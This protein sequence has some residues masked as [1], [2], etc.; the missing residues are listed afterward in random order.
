MSQT[1]MMPKCSILMVFIVVFM[2][3]PAWFQLPQFSFLSTMIRECT[4]DLGSWKVIKVCDKYLTSSSSCL[5]SNLWATLFHVF[6]LYFF[7]L[8][9]FLFTDSILVIATRAEALIIRLQLLAHEWLPP[10][11]CENL[12]VSFPTNKACIYEVETKFGVFSA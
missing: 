10:Y 11:S 5:S 12:F 6:N 2:P 8:K 4:N 1:Y 7:N 9:T 3:R